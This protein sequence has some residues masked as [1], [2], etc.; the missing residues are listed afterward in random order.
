MIHHVV[1]MGQ[2]KHV[3]GI[4]SNPDAD[5]FE[6]SDVIVAEAFMKILPP[7]IEDIESRIDRCCT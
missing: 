7:L 5:I 3:P 6:A 4:N 2:S 1:G